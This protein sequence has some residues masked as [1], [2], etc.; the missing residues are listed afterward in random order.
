MS[1]IETAKI[2]WGEKLPDWIEV[3]ATESD[4]TSQA[5]TARKIGYSP[6]AVNC[7]LKN[8]YKGT[9]GNVE[10]KVRTHLM[11][12]VHACPVY[13]SILIRECFENQNQ[14]FASSGNPTKIRLYKACQNCQ[15]NTTKEKSNAK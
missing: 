11:N 3:L 12:A 5:Q 9:I 15:F 13:G 14:P 6:A 4:K 8:N 1:A 10:A 7:V 2:N